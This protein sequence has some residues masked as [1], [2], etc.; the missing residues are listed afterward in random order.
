MAYH[1]SVLL[2]ECIEGLA[3]KPDGIYVDVTFG[4]GGHSKAIME[5]LGDGGRLIAFD[6]DTDALANAF[7]DKRLT[8]VHANFADLKKFLRLHGITKVDG[9]LA[10]LGVSSYQFD[11]AGRGFSYRF[12][13]PL[14]MRMNQ[15]AGQS[16]SDVLNT[17]G[18][19]ALVNVFSE[20]GEVPNSKRLA[21]AV[22][23]KRMIAPFD[24]IQSLMDLLQTTIIGDRWKY[25]SQVFQAIR[26]EVN[27][28]TNVL[29]SFLEQC[30]EVLK[31]DGRLA[32][33]TFHSIEDRLVKQY[34][35]NGV[36]E[37][38]PQKD[39]YGR[40][41]AP[42]KVITKKPI[43][44]TAEEQK[45]NTRSRSAKLRIGAKKMEG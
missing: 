4:G 30:G 16:A 42:F 33:I 12:D 2:K 29:K 41:Y 8:L 18:E 39:M 40:F 6:Q 22:I 7:D 31:A 38:E 43:V 9:I 45:G 44:A 13:G 17:Y 35:K 27:Q 25:L 23:E 36:F 28:E 20:Y 5:C 37:D 21:K 15:Q 11:T 19:E 3:I 24:T 34:M 10:D 26:M 32:V 14:D 1:E